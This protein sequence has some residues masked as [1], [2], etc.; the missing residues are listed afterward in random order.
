MPSRE[1]DP[2]DAL[3]QPPS[4]E[5]AAERTKRLADEAEARRISHDID[6]DI[7]RERTLRKKKQIV[8]LLLLG[9]SESGKSTTLRQFQWLYTPSAFR[10]ERVL[11]R[12][13]IQLNLVRSIRLILDTI[14]DV[15]KHELPLSSASDEASD[16][17]SASASARLPMHLESIAM[18]LL[19]LRHIE[20]LLIAKLVP[21]NEEEATHLGVEMAVSVT[22]SV[23]GSSNGGRGHG[24]GHGQSQREIFVR[25]GST[26]KGGM[27]GGRPQSAGTHG[28]ETQ[29]ESQA[30]L[31]QCGA[32]MLALW[33]DGTVRDILRK[34]KVR[35]E[36]SPGFYLDDLPRLTAL[37]YTP[38]DED[39]FKAR[40]KT[41][42]VC[43]HK[44]EMEAGFESGTEWRIIDV[45]GSRSQRPT[46]VPFFDDAIIFLAPISAFDQ[47]L[48]EDKSVN[49][50][51]DSVML[52]KAVCSNK[53][54]AKVELILFMNKCDILDQKLRAG[55][56]LARYLRSFGDRPND[57]ENAQKF[58]R[59]RFSHIHR[60]HSPQPRKFHGYFTS[61]TDTSTTSGILASVREMV[62][63]EH[64]RK[65]KLLS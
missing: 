49:R 59:S 17:E 36:E 31:N 37:N 4:N 61:V 13:V 18:R 22:S 10:A 8:K 53:L 9:Q 12:S 19:P 45:G 2:L 40:L 41:V 39:V 26:W 33:K 60:E 30:V 55:V 28:Q 51:E 63:R 29:D 14:S 23:S 16:D 47:T 48:V 52:W 58:F 11:W 50:L 44:F 24:H 7:K 15:R 20:S 54:L 64:L 6:E 3:M 5:S 42:G 34:R 65:A 35:L 62:M 57:L 27:G 25:P 21:P 38:S 43:E 56:R 1:P 32:D 46:W